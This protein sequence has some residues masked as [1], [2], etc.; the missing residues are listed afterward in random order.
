MKSFNKSKVEQRPQLNMGFRLIA[1]V[2]Q[3]MDGIVLESFANT[4][5]KFTNKQKSFISPQNF[6]DL[7]PKPLVSLKA[8]LTL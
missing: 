7:F 2:K 5:E 4:R 1:T 6:G 3:L 8:A